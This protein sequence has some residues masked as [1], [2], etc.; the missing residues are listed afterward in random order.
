[1]AY[2]SGPL[3][4]QTAFDKLPPCGMKRLK[5]GGIRQ[6]MAPSTS[7]SESERPMPMSRLRYKSELLLRRIVPTP[8]AGLSIFLNNSQGRCLNCGVRLKGSLRIGFLLKDLSARH[9]CVHHFAETAR[10]A[11]NRT[12]EVR[13]DNGYRSL[14][15]YRL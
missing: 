10:S 9:Q 5:H 13:Q 6:K 15:D 2:N 12:L 8:T 11:S 4:L 7:L 14:L 1:M 3:S